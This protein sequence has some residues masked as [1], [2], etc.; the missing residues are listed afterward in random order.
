MNKAVFTLL[1]AL[2]LASCGQTGPLVLP[3]AA[4]ADEQPANEQPGQ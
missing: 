4:P 1:T 2:L 3:E